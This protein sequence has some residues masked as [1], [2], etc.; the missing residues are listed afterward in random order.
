[1]VPT[2]EDEMLHNASNAS[3]K[4]RRGFSLGLPPASVAVVVDVA[5]VGTKEEEAE[6]TVIV[7]VVVVVAVVANTDVMMDD[8]R[9][10]RKSIE[11]R[12]HSLSLSL[13]TRQ[14]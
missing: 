14:K 10:G 8:E 4:F 3:V 1:V 9:I 2:A 5:D 13:Y 11:D 7:F 6:D 12:S